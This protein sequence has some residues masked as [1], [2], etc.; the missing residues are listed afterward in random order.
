MTADGMT[1]SSQ[2]R[3]RRAW[4]L[5]QFFSASGTRNVTVSGPT[6]R[7]RWLRVVSIFSAIAGDGDPTR[8]AAQVVSGIGFLGAGIICIGV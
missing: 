3:L 5:D 6:R 2:P 1:L 4:F 8:L 7:W